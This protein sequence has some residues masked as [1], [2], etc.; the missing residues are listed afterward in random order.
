MSLRYLFPCSQCEHKFELVTKQAG[1]ELTCPS[2]GASNQAP[3]LGTLKQ[4]EL[5]DST[6]NASKA[7]RRNQNASS[8]SWRNVIFV[9]GL[10]LAIIAGAAGFALFRFAQSKVVEFDVAGNLEEYNQWLDEQSAPIVLGIYVEA[11]SSEGLPEWIEAPHVGSNKQAA[12]LK[13]FAY[14]LFGLASLGLLTL[15]GSFLVPS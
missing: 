14:G 15:L 10:A 5:A 2:C 11:N 6:D 12:I 4:L 7:G 13:N 1:Q 8:G 9:T 3:K